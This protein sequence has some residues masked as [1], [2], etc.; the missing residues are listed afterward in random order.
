MALSEAHLLSGSTPALPPGPPYAC[1]ALDNWS[2]AAFWM[3]PGDVRLADLHDGGD[4]PSLAMDNLQGLVRAWAEHPEWLDFLDPSAPNHADKMLERALYIHHWQGA[5]P[6]AGRVLDLGGGCGRFAAWLLDQGLDVEVVDPDLRSLWRTL[7][8][9]AG[10]PGRIDLH[11]TT[12]EHLP[13]LRAVDA[14]VAAE[15]LCYVEDPGR[16]LDNARRLLKPG[17]R[18]LCS[19]ESRWGWASALDAHAG[20]LD[21]LLGDGV[22]HVPG[23]VWVRTFTQDALREL[24]ADWEIESLIPTHYVP[25][26]PFEAVAGDLDLDLVLAAEERLR[27]TA[28]LRHLN[29]AWMAVARKPT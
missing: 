21:A 18:L 3:P 29:R 25:S 11:W 23:D 14:V 8:H 15:V 16:I 13:D 9:A 4:S 24:L 12:G 5:L 10:R 26:G 2:G 20:T 22:V 7:Q 6:T 17:G 19:V 1:E 28:E 27:A